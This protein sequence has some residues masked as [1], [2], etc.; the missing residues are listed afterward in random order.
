MTNL[1]EF[2]FLSSDGKD[3]APPH[4]VAAGGNARAVLQ[5]SHGS[6]AYRPLD[7]FARYLNEQGLAVVATPSWATAAP[8]RRAEPPSTLATAPVG[9]RW[10]ISSC[11]TSSCGGSFSVCRCAS[12]AT[13]WAPSGPQLPDPLS[14]H[15]AGRHYHG[16][17]LAATGQLIGGRAV[18]EVVCAARTL[19]RQQA[20]ERSGLRRLQQGLCSPTAPAM[21]GC[22][23]TPK[24]W[25]AHCRPPL[26]RRCHGGGCSA[27]CSTASPFNQNPKN[28]ARMDSSLPV[29][30][31]SGD[32]DP[33]GDMGKVSP[34]PTPSA[35][36]A[37]RT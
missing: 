3:P 29:L 22:R 27:R 8:C 34:P 28:L 17:R 36:R 19:R 24:M 37:C 7:G 32:R 13:A 15:P 21:T 9:R 18:A 10:R 25:T 2:T 35:R 14:R 4:A 1:T 12:W 5:I 31:I 20:G 33:V 6:R 11:C 23:R 26:R 16:Y 30:L